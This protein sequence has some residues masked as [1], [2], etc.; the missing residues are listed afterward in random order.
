MIT[1]GKKWHYLDGYNRPVRSLSRLLRGI[2]SNHN[3][4]FYCLNCFHS[5]STETRLKK[6]DYCHVKMPNEC[7]KTLEY[8]HGE[9]S[10]KVPFIIY[11]DLESLLP[12][13]NACQNN[14]EKSYT[15]WKA[16]H[17]TSGWATIVKCSFDATKD[18]YDYYR[19]IDCIEKL[20]KRLKDYAMEIINY[21]EKEII[22]LTDKENK[23]YEMQKTCH[24]C[25]KGFCTDE[26]EKKITKKSEI[27]AIKLENLQEQL[28][29][30][31]ISD[32]KYLKKSL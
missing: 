27:I 25:K 10:L 8:N 20:C 26:N 16:K 2:T 22:S 28:I 3:G 30:F 19:E 15:K 5:Y 9:K 17:K 18:R 14:L 31:A 21:E 6:H 1:D 12:K 29:V 11:L 7:K 23:S 13:M 24:I 32:T 4:D